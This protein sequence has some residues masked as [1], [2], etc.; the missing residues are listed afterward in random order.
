M[1]NKIFIILFFFDTT[2]GFI[3]YDCG[4]R[5]LNVTT[6][7]LRE[8]GECDIPTT[9]VNNMR[10]YLQLLQINEYTDTTIIQS[11]IEIHRTIFYCGMHSHVSIVL[12]GENEY[13]IDVNRESCI[14][15]HKTGIIKISDT[16][17]VHGI[18]INQTITHGLFLAGQVSGD[19]TVEGTGYSDPF[20]TWKN[21]L[22]QGTVEITLTEQVARIKLEADTIYLISG[23]V[24]SLSESTCIDQEG[25]HTF[26]NTIPIDSC[27][28]QHHSVL[29]EG[30]AKK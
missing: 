23:T 16:H 20:G 11:K 25:G 4:S 15:A 3:R 12:N 9:T 28:F 8:V 2:T 14:D 26:W 5:Q 18:K 21:V 19:A 13:I 29:Y 6:L 30:F 17:V 22:V 27:K 24:C 1:I 10:Q 7:S